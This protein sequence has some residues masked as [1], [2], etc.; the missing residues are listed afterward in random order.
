MGLKDWYPRRTSL[1]R[2]LERG[3]QPGASLMDELQSLEDY[4]IRSRADAKAVCQVL[5]QLASDDPAVGGDSALRAVTALLQQVEG[6]ECPAFAV[7]AEQGTVLLIRI[8][9][10]ALHGPSRHTPDELLFALKVL[11]LYGTAEGT[12]AIV[13]AARQP[14]QPDDFMWSVILHPFG[15]GHPESERL[16]HELSDPL[17]TS[18]LAVSLLDCANAAQ[19]DGFGDPH[20]FDSPRGIESLEAWLTDKAP[21]HFSYAVSAA[22]ALPFINRPERDALLAIA[23][24]HVDSN[25]QMEAAWAAAKLGRQA[26][27]S[28]LARSCLDVQHSE[29]ARAY[30]TELERQDAIPAEA[31]SPD[32][33]A[34]AD[35]ASWLA[36]PNELGRPA[37]ELEIVDHRELHWPPDRQLKP[38]WLIKYRVRDRTGLEDDTIG[39]GLVGSVTF[40]LFYYKLEERPPE[41]GYAIH[42]YWE[43]EAHG[44]IADIEVEA[45]STEYDPLRSQGQ[46][47]GVSQDRLLRV[48]EMS[49]ELGYPQRLVALARASRH[50]EPGWIVLDGPR[51]RWYAA[52]EMPDTPFDTIIL[53]LHVGRVLLGFEEEPDRRGFLR[54]TAAKRMPAQVVSAYERLLDQA[55]SDIGQARELL[56][57]GG[58]LSAKFTEYVTA[59]A[60]ES[61]QSTAACTCVAYEAI[62]S[63]AER[64]A[65]SLSREYLR[66]SAPLAAHLGAYITALLELNRQA[67]IPAIIERFR[68]HMDHNAG[69]TMLG[70]AAF[71]GGHDELA[72]SFFVKLRH[73]MKD[74]C[75]SEGMNA[76]AEIWQRQGRNEEAHTLQIDALHGI[77]EQSRTA[78]GSDCELFEEWF[79]NR[80][81]AYL[82]LFA[83]RGN[84]ELQRHGIPKSSGATTS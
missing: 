29:R 53:M 45:S 30:L 27:I 58:V 73:S 34:K 23:F 64:D 44:L 9:D 74:W 54:P 60:S 22:A 26:G 83:D 19:R 1:Q 28:W 42:C 52:A 5:R 69:Y 6:A 49:P 16:F 14:L 79:Q 41:D 46:L 47:E 31:D 36:H 13:R 75:R 4:P 62:L 10:S 50:G 40:C 12:D 66:S 59:L 81:S 84:E 57:G 2:A 21:E 3:T 67:E 78:T 39:L 32:F 68:P 38:L 51:S 11:A 63:V 35:F 80:R 18:F 72:E 65:P 17:P 56:G 25:V 76:L 82:R 20:P 7:F 37:D 71:K 48:A 55:R 43:M 8:V 61:S 24:D 77:M 70:N 33:R 15:V